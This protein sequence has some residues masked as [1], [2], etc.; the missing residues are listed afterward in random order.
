MSWMAGANEL[1]GEELDVTIATFI[2]LLAAC[3]IHPAELFD[4]LLA[5]L[6][7][8][9]KSLKPW[10]ASSPQSSCSASA[11]AEAAS[12]PPSGG[13]PKKR[14]WDPAQSAAAAA[15]RRYIQ[16]KLETGDMWGIL[17]AKVCKM[18][19]LR[20]AK[21]GLYLFGSTPLEKR[22]VKH[23]IDAMNRALPV[24][25]GPGV[26]G[27]AVGRNMMR[28]LQMLDA[29][30]ET[31]VGFTVSSDGEAQTRAADI[32]ER[33]VPGI[34]Q[35]ETMVFMRIDIHPMDFKAFAPVFATAAEW[36]LEP[37]AHRMARLKELFGEFGD[38]WT[39][40]A[41]TAAGGGAGGG[42]GAACGGGG[43]AAAGVAA[44]GAA[45]AGATATGEGP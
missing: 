15:K 21:Y 26:D 37:P 14:K 39:D 12:C 41:A 19:L 28:R 38:G 25:P 11:D 42:G 4:Q 32:V 8:Y 3:G 22:F 29:L 43:D 31:I 9:I 2:Q 13:A 40:D 20:G 45:A 27:P 1:D 24:L 5:A 36:K 34:M 16:T 6:A 7:E 18:P 23:A 33:L 10:L 17:N 44:A 35:T 30:L